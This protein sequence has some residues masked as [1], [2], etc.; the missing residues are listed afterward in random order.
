MTF[1]VYV[2]RFFSDLIHLKLFSFHIVVKYAHAFEATSL[3][4]HKVNVSIIAVREN[5]EI[6]ILS[7]SLVYN[8]TH[9]LKYSITKVFPCLEVVLCMV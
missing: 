4:F 2:S 8:V 7:I 6:T 1:S 3:F 5:N 9:S